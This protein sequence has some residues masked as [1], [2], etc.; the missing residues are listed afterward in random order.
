MTPDSH[1]V[2]H[3][4]RPSTSRVCVRCT[5][6]GVGD[7]RPAH[8]HDAAS[9]ALH[10]HTV[11]DTFSVRVHRPRQRSPESG[12]RTLVIESADQVSGHQGSGHALTASIAT[13][14]IDEPDPLPPSHPVQFQ[15]SHYS[16]VITDPVV[17]ANMTWTG[18]PGRGPLLL[19]HGDASVIVKR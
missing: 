3:A 13:R 5:A 4:R 17:W 10:C 8:K 7:V 9:I 14:G 1:R 12:P 2:R 19:D 15:A 18:G 16:W 6:T 11:H